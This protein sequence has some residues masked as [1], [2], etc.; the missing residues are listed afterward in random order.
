MK[1]L[2]KK[3]IHFF[4]KLIPLSLY[5]GIIQPKITGLIYHAVSDNPLPHINYIYPPV[6]TVHFEEALRYL[7]T[8]YNV[9]TYDQL[10]AHRIKGKPLPD[11]A[12]HLSFDDG[13]IECYTLVC[14]L[15]KKYN[16]PCTFFITSNWIDNKGM[17]FRNKVG[18]CIEK[19]NTF[20]ETEEFTY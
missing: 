12:M 5:R 4:L 19:L 2:I 15:L 18:L 9:I 6:T 14:P 20:D 16:I 8:N 3:I 13:Y 1:N 7:K 17:F 10:H 11:R